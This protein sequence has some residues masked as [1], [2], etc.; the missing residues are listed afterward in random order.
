MLMNWPAGRKVCIGRLI[1]WPNGV[2]ESLQDQ[3]RQSHSRSRGQSASHQWSPPRAQP[4]ASCACGRVL[5]WANFQSCGLRHECSRYERILTPRR[6]ADIDEVGARRSQMP[7]P[8]EDVS[9]TKPDEVIAPPA[10]PFVRHHGFGRT[11]QLRPLRRRLDAVWDRERP[12]PRLFSRDLDRHHHWRARRI[13]GAIGAL[14][15]SAGPS[16]CVT[17]DLD[18]HYDGAPVGRV[19][20]SWAPS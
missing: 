15:D 13:S 18:C 5:T 10:G 19:Q 4:L 12:G 11:L 2:T 17:G 16:G 8:F 3:S 14:G 9:A 1:L 6:L 20:V 7:Q